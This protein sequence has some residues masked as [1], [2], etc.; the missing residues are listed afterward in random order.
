MFAATPILFSPHRRIG[1]TGRR[2][3]PELAPLEARRLL[4][5]AADLTTTAQVTT[6]TNGVAVVQPV[7][8]A[9]ATR[10]DS[11]RIR[12]T[13]SDPDHPRSTPTTHF[14]ITDLTTRTVVVN[15]GVGTSWTLAAQGDYQVQFWSTDSDDSEPAAAHTIW[16]SIDRTAPVISFD[17]VSPSILWPPNG[18][19]VAVT[20]TGVAADSLSGVNPSTLRFSVR[21][22]YGMVQPSGAITD[23]RETARTLFGGLEDVTFSFQVMLQAR[24]HGFDFDGRQYSITVTGFDL[25]GNLGSG[26]AMVLVPHDMG[27]HSE[28]HHGREGRHSGHHHGRDR[29]PISGPSGGSHGLGPHRHETGGRSGGHGEPGSTPVGPGPVVGPLPNPNDGHGHGHGSSDGDGN[30]NGKGNSHGHGN[31]KDQGHGGGDDNGKDQGNGNGHGQGSGD[32]GK[33]HG[34]G[35]DGH[36]HGHDKDHG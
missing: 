8:P 25:A 34:D 32:G 28:H 36:G 7:E 21:D 13:A 22:E 30:G 27:H 18:K 6:I 3:V 14:N 24:R 15:N 12:F 35:G 9:Y 26:S 23:I 29:G 11:V 2:C 20:V 16:V 1:R 19:F 4:S 17:T 31:G 33:D 10:A 5:A